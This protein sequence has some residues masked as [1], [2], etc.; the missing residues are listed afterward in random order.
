M[1]RAKF[2]RVFEEKAELCEA[3]VGCIATELATISR[4]NIRKILQQLPHI[5]FGDSFHDIFKIVI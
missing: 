1:Y 3:H 2:P 5:V 4:E